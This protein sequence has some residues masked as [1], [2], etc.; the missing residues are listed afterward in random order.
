GL[1][2][3]EIKAMRDQGYEVG[4][5]AG[6]TAASSVVGPIIPP[7]IPL[8]IYGAIAQVSVGQLFVAGLF[9]GLLLALS[10]SLVI[11]WMGRGGRFPREARAGY[12]ERFSVLGKAGLSLATPAIILAGLIGGIFTPTEAGAVAAFYALLISLFVYRTI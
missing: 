4:F 1:G 6:V 11:V 5:S 9:P 10:L 2:A 7:S 8:V 3:I 12:R